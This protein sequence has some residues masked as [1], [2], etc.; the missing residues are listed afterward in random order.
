LPARPATPAAA[1]PANAPPVEKVAAAE[2]SVAANSAVPASS[3]GTPMSTAPSP[4]RRSAPPTGPYADERTSEG[5]A[6]SP[7]DASL[8]LPPFIVSPASVQTQAIAGD[9]PRMVTIT[10]RSTGDRE[11]DVRRLRC[12]HGALQSCPGRDRFAFLV[13]ESGKRYLLEFPNETTGVGSELIGKLIKFAGEENIRIDPL[14]I[15]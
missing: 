15:Q 1:R 10:L 12:I 8:V 11:R 3:A 5:Y 2:H 6:F 14:K 13:F 4:E 7:P 9:E